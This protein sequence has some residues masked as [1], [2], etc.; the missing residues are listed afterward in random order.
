MT[1]PALTPPDE[2]T[3]A[4]R[5]IE[6][7]IDECPRRQPTSD[8]ERR[9]Q[10]LV[11]EQYEALG[12]DT[13]WHH[14]RFNDNLYANLALHA[15]VA[16]AGMAVA[17]RRPAI[18]ALLQLGAAASYVAESTR[19]GYALRRV[20]PWKPSQNLLATLPARGALRL[21]VVFVAHADAA[22]TGLLF[23]P[24][25]AARFSGSPP[26][27]D[28][29]MR[30]VIGTQVASGALAMLEALTGRAVVPAVARAALAFPSLMAGALNADVV[31]R[32]T[33]VPG[34][35]D[36]LSGTVGALLLA[37]RLV[38]DRP[39]GI[40]VVFVTT[41][42]EEA[43]LG[44]SDALA[45]SM[46]SCW[47][48]DDTVVIGIDGFSNGDLFYFTEG[49]VLPVPSSPELHVVLDDVAARDPRFAQVRALEIPVGGTD[50]VPFAL[51][52]YTAVTIGRVDP[53]LGMPRHYHHPSDTPAN[54]DAR[55]IPETVD[56]VEAVFRELVERRLG[57]TDQRSR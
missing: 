34:A 37:R 26:P 18:G 46:R 51:R 47:S 50:A 49:E 25:F 3:W 42:C 48:C 45:R 57:T 23:E 11:A 4:R 44:G 28:K 2:S 53:E 8:D 20:F 9:A 35:N 33:I 56:Y 30:L 19:V 41:G 10:E 52:G 43:S 31:R 55:Q 24:A 1:A 27:F 38:A 6:R 22:F 13:S 14:F 54:L 32:D 7:I 16:L 12:L 15:G 21:R 39:D 40:E 36:N 29:S 17:R 5:I